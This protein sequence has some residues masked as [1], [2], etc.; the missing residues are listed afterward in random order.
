MFEEWLYQ[1]DYKPLN[2]EGYHTKAQ[3]L[4]MF[5]GLPPA[6]Q[7]GV[8]REFFESKGIW[9]ESKFNVIDSVIYHLIKVWQNK[10]CIFV[11]QN[12]D[13]NTAFNT[14]IETAGKLLEG[15]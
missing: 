12:K 9:I 2:R 8:W 11:I 5:N 4:I 15:K 1:K 6:M 10:T 13:Y 3:I 14:A 7:Q